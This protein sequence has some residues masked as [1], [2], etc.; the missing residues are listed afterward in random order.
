[1]RVRIAAGWLV[2][3][4]GL[5]ACTTGGSGS[6]QTASARV[7]DT[8]AL[9]ELPSSPDRAD[10]SV[11]PN[12]DPTTT[13]TTEPP[14]PTIDG[15]IGD[16]VDGNRVLVIGDGV[17]ATVAPDGGGIVCDVLVDD[18]GWAVETVAESGR[19]I[20]LLPEV[21]D[22]RFQPS[23]GDDWDAVI[24]M[25]GNVSEDDV[26]RYEELLTEALDALT[27][28]P[29]V[30]FTLSETDD[31]A[32]R[33]EIIRAAADRPN[34]VV[35]DWAELSAAESNLLLRN[36]GPLPTQEGSG[37]LVVFMAGELG[38]APAGSVGECLPDAFDG[39]GN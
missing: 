11:P 19:S 20:E 18:F 32:E 31:E 10:P 37:R 28:R 22:A 8:V 30:L 21:L 24:I 29:V 35:V 4:F 5:A 6:G 16:I 34:V 25:L 33:N 12:L 38:D 27:P 7:V 23:A 3:A 2:V 9:G 36:G 17:F 15:P 26:A 13:T 39:S 14:I 1:M